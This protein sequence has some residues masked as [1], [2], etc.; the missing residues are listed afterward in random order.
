MLFDSQL[1]PLVINGD[2]NLPLLGVFRD[3]SCR[4]IW[5]SD[6]DH[7]TVG[8]RHLHLGGFIRHF[9]HHGEL[10]LTLIV[11]NCLQW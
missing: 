6:P 10:D 9:S 2:T 3:A 7:H 8:S 1:S 4:F 11:T 5:R